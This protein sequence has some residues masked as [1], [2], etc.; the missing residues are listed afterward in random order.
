MKYIEY[1]DSV[2]ITESK[3]ISSLVGDP[4]FGMVKLLKTER[5]YV[6]ALADLMD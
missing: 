3:L 1:T 2:D 5:S 6:A 4:L